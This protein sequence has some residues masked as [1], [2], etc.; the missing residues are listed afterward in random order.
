MSHGGTG[1]DGSSLGNADSI[2]SSSADGT[3][4]GGGGGGGGGSG[5]IRI[6]CSA[7]TVDSTLVAPTPAIIVK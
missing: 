6:V 2:P 4:G 7:C 3:L 5:F 1:S